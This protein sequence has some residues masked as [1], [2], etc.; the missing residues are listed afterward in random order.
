[1]FLPHRGNRLFQINI[2][3]LM[4]AAAGQSWWGPSPPLLAGKRKTCL[5]ICLRCDNSALSLLAASLTPPPMKVIADGYHLLVELKD[6]GPAFQF[7][8]LYWKKGQESRVSFTLGFWAQTES[9]CDLEWKHTNISQ[10]LFFKSKMLLWSWRTCP[11]A[12]CAIFLCAS[13]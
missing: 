8:V 13:G 7:C 4:V 11:E 3:V 2:T 5:K 9:P 12:V 10:G 6:M 1:M